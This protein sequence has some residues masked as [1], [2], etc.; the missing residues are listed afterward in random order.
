MGRRRLRSKLL[1]VRLE[2]TIEKTDLHIDSSCSEYLDSEGI[3]DEVETEAMR[4]VRAWQARK[5]ANTEVLR[6]AQDDED[7]DR[8][9][10]SGVL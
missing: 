10:D 3:R 6:C 7:S 9:D 5:E 4:R 8:V 1:S 2:G